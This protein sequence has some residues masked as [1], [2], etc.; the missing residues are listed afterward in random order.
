MR[1]RFACS[2]IILL[3]PLTLCLHVMAQVSA[4]SAQAI[5][6]QLGSAPAVP[7]RAELVPV[8]RLQGLEFVSGSG[9]QI[10]LERDGKR[11]LIDTENRT[12]REF[13]PTK[14]TSEQAPTASGEAGAPPAPVAKVAKPEEK[15]E[16]ETYYTEDIVLPRKADGL[17]VAGER[18]E[19]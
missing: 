16:P 17:S 4:E 18:Q 9:S 15:K 6:S 10:V 7:G 19:S 8:P 1:P 5:S 13:V 2:F 11:Y 3:A 12:I 14:V